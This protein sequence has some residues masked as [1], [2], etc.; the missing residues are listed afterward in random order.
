MMAKPKDLVSDERARRAGGVPVAVGD[1]VGWYSL[2][3]GLVADADGAHGFEAEISEELERALGTKLALSGGLLVPP[4]V[5]FGPR[6]AL[7]TGTTNAGEEFVFEGRGPFAMA[8]RPLPRVQVLGATVIPGGRETLRIV[9]VTD[10]GTVA[11]VPEVPGSPVALEDLATA[12][13]TLDMKLGVIGTAYSRDIAALS[14]EFTDLLELELRAAAASAIDAGAVAG[15]GTDEPEGLLTRADVPVVAMGDPDGGAPTW[16][17]LAEIEEAPAAADVDELASGW[18]TT[19]GVRRKLRETALLAT[20]AAGPVWL[21]QTLLGHRALVSS[22]V[23]SDL[24]KGAGTN[25][26]GLL[27]GADWS[28]L[29]VHVLAVEIVTDPFSLKKQGLIEAI[30]YV[31]VGVGVRHPEA[32]V[33][34][35]D[36]DVS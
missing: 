36:V 34:V 26:H 5:L 18:L 14:P 32:F 1:S 4:A 17:L 24:T 29:V 35:V 27:F 20:A 33:K 25:L 19:A 7:D 28:S 6:A 13:E 9:R 3:R 23:P 30:V 16:A 22:I 21:G 15:A 8:R 31:H 2:G 10:G 11:W 12:D